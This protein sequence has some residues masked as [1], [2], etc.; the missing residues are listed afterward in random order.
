MDTMAFNNRETA[1]FRRAG[2]RAQHIEEST[3][4]W[5]SPVFVIKKKSGKWRMVTDLRAINKVIQPIDI[6]AGAGAR[7]GPE[8]ELKLEPALRHTERSAAAKP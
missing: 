6:R 3:N 1:G 2:T 4:P 8:L 5:N 7:A